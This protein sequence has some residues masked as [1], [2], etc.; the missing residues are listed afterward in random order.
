MRDIARTGR[1]ATPRGTG[2]IRFGPVSLCVLLTIAIAMTAMTA[3]ARDDPSSFEQR[4]RAADAIRS[5]DPERFR[6]ELDALNAEVAAEDARATRDGVTST[7]AVNDADE[8]ISIALREELRYLNAYRHSFEGDYETGIALA[9]SLFETAS[10][11]SLRFRAG[12]L[13]VNSRAA[14]RDFHSGLRDLERSLEFVDDLPDRDLRNSGLVAAAIFYNQLGQYELGRHHAER[15]AAQS[16]SER[17]RCFAEHALFEALLKLDALPDSEAPLAAAIERCA[18][19]G[20]R[21]VANLARANLARKWAA[22]GDVLRAV[23]LLREHLTEALASGYPRLIG[24]FHSLLGEWSLVLGD[25]EAAEHHARQAIEFSAGITFSLPLVAAHRTLYEIA[26]ARGDAA[27]ALEHYRAYAEADRAYLNDVK[28][29]EMSFQTV[30]HE[31]LQ[32]TQTIDLLNKQNEVL[33]LE[34]QVARQSWRNTQIV[35]VLLAALLASIGYWAMK[36]KRMQAALKRMAETDGL[37]GVG[38]RGHFTRIT[39]RVLRNCAKTERPIALVMLDIDNFKAVNDR[40]G[41]PT[42]DWV[43]KKVAEACLA[44]CGENDRVGRIG[45]EEFAILC[46]DRDRVAAVE[47]AERCREGIAAIDPSEAGSRFTISASFGIATAKSAG[48]RIDTL[49]AQADEALYRA[50]R[51]GRNRVFAYRPGCGLEGTGKTGF[52]M[53]SAALR[54]TATSEA[55]DPAKPSA[56]VG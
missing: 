13:T 43:L 30:R 53:P 41:H 31:T 8:A 45:G 2:P 39:E 17:T 16:D 24:E 50:K 1:R 4:V 36:M 20:E 11:P 12:I 23:G 33:Q 47:L 25:S 42:G 19:Q 6:R 14:T 52:P 7:D 9:Q 54:A 29:R 5:S 15:A 44:Q 35:A 28:A 37:T 55:P 38:N 32:K 26:L 56:P 46:R 51:D 21:V 18:A 3:M 40:H 27:T 49:L 22:Q 48:Y 10:D 34:Q